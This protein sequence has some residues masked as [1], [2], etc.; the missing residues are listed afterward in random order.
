V[1]GSNEEYVVAIERDFKNPLRQLNEHF[2]KLLKVACLNHTFPIKHKLKECTIMKN[3]MT[4][5]VPFEGKKA[6]GDLGRKGKQCQEEKQGAW[7][8]QAWW[9]GCCLDLGTS[10]RSVGLLQALQDSSHYIQDIT[11]H[12]QVV[13]DPWNRRCQCFLH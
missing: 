5:V 11:G 3:F 7:R 13:G 6:E 9:S 10:T 4:S 1:D 8:V 2:E 12:A